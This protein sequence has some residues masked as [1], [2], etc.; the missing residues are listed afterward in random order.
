MERP[1]PILKPFQQLTY[2]S[3]C[4]ATLFFLL[5]GR[6]ETAETTA[7]KPRL[8]GFTNLVS[9]SKNLTEEAETAKNPKLESGRWGAQ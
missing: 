9:F 3:A 6:V 4:F 1:G 8:A 7:K 2:Y 5:M